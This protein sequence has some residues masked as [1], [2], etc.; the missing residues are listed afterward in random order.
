MVAK[1]HKNPLEDH[2]NLVMLQI[3]HK[4]N[5]KEILQCMMSDLKEKISDNFNQ[6]CMSKEISLLMMS[7]T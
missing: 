3:S 7:L 4:E 2:K 6:D 1:H 5:N